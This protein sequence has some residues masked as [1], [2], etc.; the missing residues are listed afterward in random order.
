MC[1]VSNTILIG[2]KCSE[3]VE[4]IQ[5]D[6]CW[7]AIYYECVREFRDESRCSETETPYAVILLLY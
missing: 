5:R 6:V 1:S 7:A 4:K 2:S 3:I